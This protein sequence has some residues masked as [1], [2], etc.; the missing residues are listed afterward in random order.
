VN[1][2]IAQATLAKA[3]GIVTKAVNHRSTLPV[4][5][6]VALYADGDGVR[7]A[8]TDLN[9]GITLW[10]PATVNDA[11]AITL[12]A[13]LFGEF[14]NSLPDAPVMLNLLTKTMTAALSC[15]RTQANIKGIDAAEYPQLAE[16]VDD[17]TA[18]TLSASTLR[19]MVD[20][21]LFAAATD[22]SRPTLTG[23][24]LDMQHGQ[25]KMAATDGYRLAVATETVE[26]DA[27]L[28]AIVPATA[29]A[30]MS[31]ILADADIVRLWVD[32][33]RKMIVEATAG[34][35]AKW[36]RACVEMSLIDAK[37]PDYS[38]IIPKRADVKAT[39]NV[40]AL[41]KAVRVAQLFG[42]DNSNIVRLKLGDGLHVS[43]TSAEAGDNTSII[44]ARLEGMQEPFA[45]VIAMNS[46]YIL[47]MLAQL[48][49][50]DVTME[51]TQPNRPL[52]V[53]TDG[54]LY[55]C[56]PMHPPR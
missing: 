13:R 23:V 1:V 29:L 11:G 31:G 47:D 34:D 39:V 9:V 10:I 42:R 25:L 48:D 52:K 51:F 53:T 45:F 32:N 49:V 18:V 5:G 26:T 46:K 50:T 28:S 44:D 6:N 54:R 16:Q 43:A 24:K 30:T 14:V 7:V 19:T 35:K 15:G 3:L 8:A 33:G 38:A 20:A 27:E 37:Y 36:R 40:D 21:V 17:V 41:S 4:L 12:P 55:V 2:T 56:M 22:V